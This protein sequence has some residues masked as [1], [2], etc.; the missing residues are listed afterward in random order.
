M[1]DDSYHVSACVLGTDCTDCGGVD[2]IVDYTKA[3][4]AGS[5]VETCTNTYV[6]TFQHY[7]PLVVIYLQFALCL[8][9]FLSPFLFSAVLILLTHTQ[10]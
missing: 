8:D 6:L 3:P 2:K 5:G 7:V 4:E 10:L 9:D 1:A